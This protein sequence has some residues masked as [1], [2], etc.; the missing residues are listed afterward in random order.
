MEYK[1]ID[2]F[3]ITGRGKVFVVENDKERENFKELM[4]KEVLIDGSKYVIKGIETH[5]VVIK[6]KGMR[7][8]LLV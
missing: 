1:S 2:S 8:G 6:R 4:G 7:I 3:W 5:Q